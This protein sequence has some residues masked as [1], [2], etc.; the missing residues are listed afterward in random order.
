MDTYL[1][2]P[3]PSV[4]AQQLP[5]EP[6]NQP[7]HRQ[8]RVSP[9]SGW[10]ALAV[11]MVAVAFYLVFMVGLLVAG[12]LIA[13]WD[14]NIEDL[15]Q[16]IPLT[17][18][19]ATVALMM[20]AAMAA[21]TILGGRRAG[22]L[23]S[24]TGRFRWPV[25]WRSA[26]VACGV[27]TVSFAI[28]MLIPDPTSAPVSAPSLSRVLTMLAVIILLVPVQS[29]AEEVVFRGLLPQTLGSKIASPWIAYGL[30]IVP[31]VA[32]HVYDVPGQISVA[33]FAI[34]AS[35][36]T[37]RSGGIELAVGL[38]VVNNLFAFGMGA[39]GLV[40]LNA[41]DTD[42]LAMGIDA[43]M[44]ILTAAILWRWVIRPLELQPVRDRTIEQPAREALA[45]PRSPLTPTPRSPVISWSHERKQHLPRPRDWRDRID[46]AARG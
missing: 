2:E 22:T 34:V 29:A 23:A 28:F 1:V 16:P 33:V 18:A 42:W 4:P 15:N 13:G 25:L 12:I 40:D 45:I 35:W 46:R 6:M 24:I 17:F 27:M 37:W 7:L 20:P 10:R 8:G 36:L 44:T 26:V 9:R 14:V 31:F 38:H 5:V 39:F 43:T 21:V 41:T 19:L 3:L 11:L 32:G 30:P